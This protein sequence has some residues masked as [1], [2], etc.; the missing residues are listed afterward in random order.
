[1]PGLPTAAPG[2]FQYQDHW[3]P[4]GQH[5]IEYPS[6]EASHPL[7][8]HHHP[9]QRQDK[10][11]LGGTDSKNLSC[12]VMSAPHS[13]YSKNL[14]ECR[15][16]QHQEH[17]GSKKNN[18]KALSNLYEPTFSSLCPTGHV[19]L[20][21]DIKIISSQLSDRLMVYKRTPTLL[22]GGTTMTQ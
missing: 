5:S 22:A 17:S 16:P 4:D 9:L 12:Q 3:Y 15:S 2:G 6:P 13:I 11:T 20:F 19:N 21:Q 14:L 8:R 10:T 7:E 18:P 1:M